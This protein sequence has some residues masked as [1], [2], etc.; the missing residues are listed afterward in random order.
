M[1]G[2]SYSPNPSFIHVHS[3][4]ST[5][6]SGN[7]S[8]SHDIMVMEE[9]MF[10]PFFTFFYFR[11]VTNSFIECFPTQQKYKTIYYGCWRAVMLTQLL[12]VP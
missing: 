12:H 10:S 6:G 5:E 9:R 3:T 11:L 2:L 4:F 1:L 8:S 7:Q